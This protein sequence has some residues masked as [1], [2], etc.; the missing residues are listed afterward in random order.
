M[1]RAMLPT[2][3]APKIPP[4]KKPSLPFAIAPITAQISVAIQKAG[5]PLFF[6]FVVLLEEE[7]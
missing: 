1:A 2:I 7:L 5:H 4:Q 3:I 6:S